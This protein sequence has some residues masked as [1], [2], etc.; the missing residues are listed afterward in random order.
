MENILALMESIMKLKPAS[1]KGTYLK[2]ISLST[3]MGPG[4]KIDPMDVSKYFKG[5][6]KN[7]IKKSETAGTECLSEH[8]VGLPRL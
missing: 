3:T 2:A 7:K 8:R 5:R 4:V 6:Y 1:S